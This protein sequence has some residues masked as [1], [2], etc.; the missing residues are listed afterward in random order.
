[1]KDIFDKCE[2][3]LARSKTVLAGDQALAAELFSAVSPPVNAGPWIQANGRRMLQFSTNDYLGLAQHPEVQAVGLEM[4]ERYGLCAPMGSRIL[5]GTTEYHRRLEQKVAEFKRTEAALTFAT[6][7]SAMMGALACVAHARDVLIMDQYAHASL[8]CGAK[9]S[10]ARALFFRHNDLED[11]ENILRKVADTRSLAIVIDGI[12]SMQ[13]DMAPLREI[14]ELKN[15]YGARLFVD[16]AHGTG[17]CGEEGRGTAA[18]FGVEDQVDLHMGT[19]SKAVGTIGGFVCGN[20][21]VI[22]FIR[23][24]APTFLFTKS[25]PISIVAS[26]EKAIDLARKAD[27]RRE[28]L[29]K[30]RER[31]QDGIRRVGFSIGGTQ[32]PI[33]PIK[34]NGSDALY[35]ADELRRDYGIWAVPVIYPGVHLGT[36]IVRLIPTAN[37]GDAD[38]DHAIDSLGAIHAKMAGADRAPDRA[39]DRATV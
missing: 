39:A 37:H 27:D 14:A 21:T 34:A 28:K 12:Y 5:T 15:K 36:S 6:G 32:S 22:D 30:N 11:L 18:L 1:L 17:V 10:G 38:I 8:V 19:F 26:T 16:D 33:T 3:F 31:L 4:A 2:A 35:I 7:S 9:I 13:G 25:L 23:Y 29:W 20:R 24:N